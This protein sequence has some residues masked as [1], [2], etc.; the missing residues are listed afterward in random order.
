VFKYLTSSRIFTLKLK[1]KLQKVG[2]T[3]ILSA[4]VYDFS[5][6]EDWD[7]YE[8]LQIEALDVDDE[9]LLGEF[10]KTGSWIENALQ[11]GGKVLI[12]W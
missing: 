3:H 6:Y 9:N 11:G 8:H 2:I 4:L 7:Q 10:E 12:H 1:S 5:K